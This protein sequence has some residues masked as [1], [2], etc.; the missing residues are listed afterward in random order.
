MSSPSG[1]VALQ[2]VGIV[3]EASLEKPE[4]H[5][6]AGR[7]PA[8]D[9]LRGLA[10][11][12]VVFHNVGF[13]Q[14]NG[15][16]PLLKVLYFA[17]AIWWVGV[18]LF[19]SLSGFLITG[20]LARSRHPGGL[21]NFWMRRA[22]R[23]FPLYYAFLTVVTVVLP[24]L[25]TMPAP[26]ANVVQY[27]GWYWAYLSNWSNWNPDH[28]VPA[29]GHFWS[30]AVEEQFYFLW[31]FVVLNFPDRTVLRVC[32]ALAGVAF[33][34][35][36]GL[37]LLHFDHSAVYD[38]TV[39]RMD[40]LTLGAAGAIAMRSPEYARSM[41]AKTRPVL[42]G[43]MLAI[44]AMWPFT[45]GFNCDLFWVQTVG[46]GVLGLFFAALVVHC[47]ASPSSLL[48][49]AFSA[50]WLSWLGK[51]SYAIYVFHFPITRLLGPRFHTAINSPPTLSALQAFLELQFLVW[52]LAILA[53]VV[54]WNLLERW[55]I[56]L[57]SRLPVR[58]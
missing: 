43:C 30:L 38:F 13:E 51:Y 28:C 54:S 53:A 34:A 42:I 10:I 12:L 56:D 57:K 58:A 55:C 19:F 18:I 17:H 7:V 6:V 37:R 48:A 9:G 41:V 40:G 4:T 23:I 2:T 47:V 22:L 8:L 11:L 46:Y 36:L 50:R 15:F 49:R 33:A 26:F 32:V 25:V 24:Y 27:R 20:I 21:S 16:V 1:P 31:P 44:L 52:A 5:L 29:L 3:G 39:T 35:R 45:R 14:E